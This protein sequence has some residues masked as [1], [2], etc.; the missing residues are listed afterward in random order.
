MK[1][2]EMVA[3]S[4][5]KNRINFKVF[6]GVEI[7]PSDFS[8]KKAIEFARKEHFDAFVAVGGGSVMVQCCSF[9]AFSFIC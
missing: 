6:D 7:E 9:I 8:M 2:V 3:A 4:L 5:A 1:P